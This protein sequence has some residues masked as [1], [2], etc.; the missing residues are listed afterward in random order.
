MSAGQETKSREQGN[1]VAIG[2]EAYN[3]ILQHYYHEA[4]LLDHGRLDEWGATLAEDISYSVPMRLTRGA[5]DLESSIV[6]SVMHMDDDYRSLMGRIIRLAGKSAWA[7][8]PP[9]RIHRF[10]SNVQVFETDNDSE[11]DVINYMLLTR[12]RFD[13]DTFDL[14]PCERHDRLRRHENGFKLAYREAIMDQALLGTPNL[15]IFL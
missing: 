14:I 9:S 7:E 3:Q 15:A 13:D 6:R 1:P 4:L 12:N 10:V 8:D 11:F 5:H 2:S